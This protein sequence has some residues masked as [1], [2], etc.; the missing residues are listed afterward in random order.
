LIQVK[1]CAIANR[2]NDFGSIRADGPIVSV[3]TTTGGAKVEHPLAP[4]KGMQMKLYATLVAG[5][6]AAV[7]GGPAFAGAGEDLIAKGKCSKCHT[8]TTTK[9]APSWASVAE[10]LKGDAGAEAKIVEFLKTGGK[11]GH[12]VVQGSDADLKAV[13]AIVL[14]SK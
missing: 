14:S 4:H 11:E 3:W 9:K 8:A 13:A 1:R 6:T 10:K 5:F 12:D 2:Q 7:I